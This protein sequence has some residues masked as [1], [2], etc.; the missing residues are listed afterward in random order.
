MIAI[1]GC[2]DEIIYNKGKL[3]TERK[4]LTYKH[5]CHMNAIHTTGI[6]H[7][8][9]VIFIIKGSSICTKKKA[10][11]QIVFH[12]KKYPYSLFFESLIILEENN[13]GYKL[14]PC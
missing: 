13:P 12:N 11:N 7:N 1:L 5:L 14:G 4:M 3:Q 6:I 9:N 2:K 8:C 10:N